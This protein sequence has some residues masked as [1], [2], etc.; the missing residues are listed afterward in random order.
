MSLL[1]EHN[2]VK[3][4]QGAKLN[5]AYDDNSNLQWYLPV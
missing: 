1:K 2:V 4:G 5:V 3:I